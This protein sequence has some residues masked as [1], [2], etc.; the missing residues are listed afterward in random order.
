[1]TWNAALGSGGA[2]IAHELI[3]QHGLLG[4]KKEEVVRARASRRTDRAACVQG[5]EDSGLA[6]DEA[7]PAIAGAAQALV[8]LLTGFC[9]RLDQDAR[10]HAI[11]DLSR[12]A[13][14][15]RFRTARLRHSKQ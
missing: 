2:Q 8:H 9:A 3:R 1:M 4:G 6:F 15:R 14:L 11:E 7:K 5:R 12:S 13:R 10:T